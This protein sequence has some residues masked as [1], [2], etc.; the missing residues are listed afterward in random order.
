M[1]KDKITDQNYINCIARMLVDLF[2]RQ[3]GYV[4]EILTVDMEDE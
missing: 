3:Y 1:I 4:P 2:E